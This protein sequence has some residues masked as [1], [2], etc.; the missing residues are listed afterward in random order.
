M[1]KQR[2]HLGSEVGI[3]K[4]WNLGC[5]EAEIVIDVD[6]W[7]LRSAA[8]L[9]DKAVFVNNRVHHRL[10]IR[11]RRGEIHFLPAEI[12]KKV[13]VIPSLEAAHLTSAITSIHCV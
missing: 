11:D 5:N 12:V 6:L 1:V 10:K 2:F 13:N 9:S 7:K 3:F 8:L 4:V